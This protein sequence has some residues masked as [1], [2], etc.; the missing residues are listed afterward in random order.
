MSSL[1]ADV[2]PTEIEM[3]GLTAVEVVSRW[4]HVGMAIVLLGGSVFMRFVLIPA[5]EPMPEADHAALR[6]RIMGRWRK[7]L[8]AG[9]GLL[10]ITGVFNY[11]RQIP[12]HKGDG[13]YHAL[14]GIKMLLAIAV[15][16]LASALAGRSAAFEGLRQARKKWLMVTI[17]LAFGIVA[18]SGFLKVARKGSPAPAAATIRLELPVAGIPN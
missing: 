7:F 17:L 9:I 11:M 3:E 2:A 1:H 5:A 14:M 8:H 13:L 10:L 16:F 12:L 4:F 18:I 6:E 15:F